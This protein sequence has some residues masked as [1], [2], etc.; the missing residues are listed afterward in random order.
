MPDL[1]SRAAAR[2]FRPVRSL[3]EA[4]KGPFEMLFDG[5]AFKAPSTGSVARVLISEVPTRSLLSAI[6]SEAGAMVLIEVAS[7]EVM[8]ALGADSG[9][10]LPAL[11]SEAASRGAEALLMSEGQVPF[12]IGVSGRFAVGRKPASGISSHDE[13]PVADAS[14]GRWLVIRRPSGVLEVKKLADD[15]PDPADIHLP[16]E[17]VTAASE[18]EGRFCLVGKRYSGRSVA[19]ASL[20]RR[21][22]EKG[23][24]HAMIVGS[25]VEYAQ[26]SP[27]SILEA[28]SLPYGETALPEWVLRASADVLVIDMNLSPVI[29][30]PLSQK[31]V[32]TTSEV[33]VDG[34]RCVA[35]SRSPSGFSASMINY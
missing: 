33:P 12:A 7:P 2:G 31:F 23:G 28:V 15:V 27:G 21:I 14:G 24:L 29:D 32:L 34:F 22:L 10:S 1:L 20:L 4:G 8:R 16:S 35:V 13:G 5:R 6:E 17:L 3:E 26:R 19:A 9:S 18:A 11:L 25:P 30:A